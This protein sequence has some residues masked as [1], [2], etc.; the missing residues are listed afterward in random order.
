M[1][2]ITVENTPLEL[3]RNQNGSFRPFYKGEPIPGATN[4]VMKQ[5]MG[6]KYPEFLVTFVGPSVRVV[7]Y[8][9]PPETVTPEPVP[10]AEWVD[11]SG[12]DRPIPGDTLISVKFRDGTEADGYA[13]DILWEHTAIPFDIM[14]YRVNA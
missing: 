4:I 3:R 7:E 14:A 11:W 12:G 10:V 5:E 6:L 9:A 13:R 8:V 1:A 2:K